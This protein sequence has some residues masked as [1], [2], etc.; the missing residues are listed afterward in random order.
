[1]LI[2]FGFTLIYIV[3]GELKRS[4]ATALMIMYFAYLAFNVS[5]FYSAE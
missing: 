1:M 2:C 5:Q 3:Q 4:G